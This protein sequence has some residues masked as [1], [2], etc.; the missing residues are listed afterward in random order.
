MTKNTKM[1]LGVAVVV[2]VGYYAYSKNWFKN[3][4][5]NFVA[6]DNYLNLTAPQGCQFYSGNVGYVGMPITSFGTQGGVIVSTG[7]GQTL[8]CPKG[9]RSVMPIK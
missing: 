1:L 6:D 8:V 9:Q 4:F 5:K 7:N 2:G 3:P